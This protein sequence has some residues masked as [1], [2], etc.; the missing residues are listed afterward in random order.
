MAD[1]TTSVGPLIRA[2]RQTRGLSQFELASRAGFSV[3]H[4]SFIETGRARPSREAMLAL[5]E[6]LGLPL[7][8]QNRLLE[9]AGFARVFRET[10][11][12][13]DEMAHMRGHAAV[14]PRSAPA[15]CR[16]RV[17]PVLELPVDQSGGHP[18]FQNTDIASPERRAQQNPARHV[19]PGR[20]APLDRELAQVERHLMSHAELAFG[21][22][23]DP[24]GVALLAEIRSYESASA[25]PDTTPPQLPIVS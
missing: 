14:H 20:H 8:E 23:E 6:V 9:A 15:L 2:R 18:V 4:V 16:G 19:P 12:S 11:I 5:S 10:P 13:A 17:G 7:C 22:A 1:A 25:V 3:W 21:S 24:A